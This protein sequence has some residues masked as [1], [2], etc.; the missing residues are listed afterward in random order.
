[1]NQF[2]HKVI[3]KRECILYTFNS[4]LLPSEYLNRPLNSWQ[5]LSS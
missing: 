3:N 2:P 4:V 5:Y 1:M